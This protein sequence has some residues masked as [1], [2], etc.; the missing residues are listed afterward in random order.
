M[1][2][3]PKEKNALWYN[4]EFKKDELQITWQRNILPKNVLGFLGNEFE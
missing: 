4:G 2:I 1:Q 3:R